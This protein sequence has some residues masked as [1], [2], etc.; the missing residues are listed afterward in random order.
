METK[1]HL[2]D[3]LMEK[4][5]GKCAECGVEITDRYMTHIDRIVRGEDGGKYVIEN[6]RLICKPCDWTK[7]GNA[8]NSPKPQLASAYRIYKMWQDMAGST[9]RKLKAYRG[10]V[11]GK[12]ASPYFDDFTLGE[13]DETLLYFQGQEHD[14]ELRLKHAVRKEPEWE[15]MKLCPG[16]GEIT[17][18]H[19]LSHIDI[20]KADTVSALWRYFGFDPTEKYNPGKGADLK[21]PLY[22]ALSICLIRTA[23]PYRADY[24]K[25]KARLSTDDHSG[26][27]QALHRCIKLWLS[28]LWE[29]WRQWAELPIQVP[30][31]NNH[32]HHT[33]FIPAT[34]RGWPSQ[35]RQ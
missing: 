8:P 31:A 20:N 33:N 26:H 25:Y 16:M 14:A 9:E 29:T 30:Y 1:K 22:A 27:G 13:L 34:D 10:E 12:T 4:Q 3:P 28:H 24:D 2:F 5:D 17:A 21:S 23:S 11:K 15:F 32:L 7:E 35:Y 18:A 19:I 6:C